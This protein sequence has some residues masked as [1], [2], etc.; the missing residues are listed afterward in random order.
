[1][2]HQ[3]RHRDGGDRDRREVLLR[4]IADIGGRRADHQLRRGAR[5]ERVSVGF[6]ARDRGRGNDAAAAALVLDHHVAEQRS[7]LLG[8]KTTNHVDDT[9]GRARHDQLD[10]PFGKPALRGR[11]W[12]AERGERKR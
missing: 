11:E 9:A 10:R 8:P 4:V 12:A 2:H 6:C 1:M 3:R 7:D 5:Q